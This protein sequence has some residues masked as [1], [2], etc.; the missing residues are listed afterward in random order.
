[1]SAE[2]PDRNDIAKIIYD[3]NPAYQ[4]HDGEKIEFNEQNPDAKHHQELAREQTAA[5]Y[6]AIAKHQRGKPV[7]REVSDEEI[8][9]TMLRTAAGMAEAHNGPYTYADFQATMINV[10]QFDKARVREIEKQLVD[11]NALLGSDMVAGI[12]LSS[13]SKAERD[14]SVGAILESAKKIRSGYRIW[15]GRFV[16]QV[17]LNYN[18]PPQRIQELVTELRAD[19]HI[20]GM[21]DYLVRTPAV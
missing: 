16:S 9:F 7:K 14:Y 8:R 17:S 1:M 12:S 19:G 6:D 3:L 5:V 20:R 13:G 15:E 11:E 10:Y 2:L 21:E 18:I 4:R